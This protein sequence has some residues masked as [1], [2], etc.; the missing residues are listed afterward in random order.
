MKK[1]G[2]T[3]AELLGVIVIMAAIAL[4]AFPPIINQIRNS[5]NDLSNTLNTLILTATR[6]YLEENNYDTNDKSFCIKLNVLVNDGK[7][8]EP[9]T[10]SKGNVVN[11]NSIFYVKFPPAL[12]S[13][14]PETSLNDNDSELTCSVKIY[15]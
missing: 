8:V 13:S 5:R 10:D 3:L 6:Q 2:F 7:L 15:N 11:L 9:I 14:N 4:I 12:A 1:N